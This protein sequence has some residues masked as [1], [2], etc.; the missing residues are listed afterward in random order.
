MPVLEI[1][2]CCCFFLFRNC[3]QLEVSFLRV[4]FS[5]ERFDTFPR[6]GSFWQFDSMNRLKHPVHQFFYVITQWRNFARAH[7]ILILAQHPFKLHVCC[8]VS[9]AH[10][11]SA[12]RTCPKEKAL[13]SVRRWLENSSVRSVV[14]ARSVY[15][16]LVL[17][18]FQS[19]WRYRSNINARILVYFESYGLYGMSESEKL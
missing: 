5:D 12:C 15:Q 3:H 16:L 7:S 8:S 17:S 14:H 11:F 1:N 13:A 18:M 19:C 6:T 4:H 2:I 9:P 10:R